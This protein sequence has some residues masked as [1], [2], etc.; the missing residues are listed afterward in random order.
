MQGVERAAKRRALHED[1][2]DRQLRRRV[3]KMMSRLDDVLSHGSSDKEAAFRMLIHSSDFA[4]DLLVPSRAQIGV[5]CG[6]DQKLVFNGKG[7]SSCC[8]K[9]FSS[10]GCDRESCY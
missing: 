5:D 10:E 7:T 1:V 9:A 4:N 6:T 2:G 3:N 8:R